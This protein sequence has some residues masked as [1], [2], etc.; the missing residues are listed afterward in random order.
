MH[1]LS[2][3]YDLDTQQQL[4]DEI[5][6]ILGDAPLF[7][8]TMPRTGKPF[9]VHMTNAGPLGWVSDK[10]GYRYQTL[11]PD[12]AEP[13]PSMPQAL[14]DLWQEVASYKALPEACLINVYDKPK[15]RMG[16]HVDGDEDD[17]TAPI[18][19]V[20]LGDNALFR[21]GGLRRTDPTSSVELR[22]GDVIV[23]GGVSRWAYHGIDRVQQ[24]T[25]DLIPGGGRVNLT[26]RRVHKP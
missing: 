12:T 4:L 2:E 15:A 17:M 10:S 3:F 23:M 8:P 19:S 5:L 18:V 20:S 6:G 22:S 16:L 13:W 7:T 11:H 1:H 9:S 24:G 25:S 14:L 26:L 21:I